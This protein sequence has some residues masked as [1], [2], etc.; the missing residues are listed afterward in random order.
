M[1]HNV[2]RV[3]CMNKIFIML[4]KENKIERNIIGEYTVYVY[5]IDGV[6]L[7]FEQEDTSGAICFVI[8][9]SNEKLREAGLKIYV[10]CNEASDVC[11]PQYTEVKVDV[12]Y[13]KSSNIDKHIEDMQYAKDICDAIMYVFKMK[14][15]YELYENG[16]LKELKG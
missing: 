5:D 1:A 7:R 4:E 2:E 13:I 15:H 8:V 12:N 16:W 11:Y 14:K 9:E 6:K 3:D 10:E